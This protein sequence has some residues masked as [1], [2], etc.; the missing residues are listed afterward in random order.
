MQFT[1]LTYRREI[2]FAAA[3]NKE[4]TTTD[5]PAVGLSAA[6]FFLKCDSLSCLREENGLPC[7]GSARN[8]LGRSP[9]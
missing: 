2:S 5:W 7:P 3:R 9:V 1:F 6:Q 8:P 4:A